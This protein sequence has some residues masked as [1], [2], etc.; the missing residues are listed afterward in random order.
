MTTTIKHNAT[1]T[2][3]TVARYFV[4]YLSLEIRTSKQL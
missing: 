2:K 3:V 1:A 4:N